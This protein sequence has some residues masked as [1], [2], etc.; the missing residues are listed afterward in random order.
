MISNLIVKVE[1]FHVFVTVGVETCE[2]TAEWNYSYHIVLQIFIAL[3][4]TGSAVS[5]V[6]SVLARFCMQNISDRGLKIRI[7]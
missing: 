1:E 2:Q 3:I 4:K 7:N 6:K 5:P